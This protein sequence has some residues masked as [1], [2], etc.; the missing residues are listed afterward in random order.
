MQKN[1]TERKNELAK[2]K[3]HDIN[4]KGVRISL[5]SK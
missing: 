2:Q 5:L 3:A 1:D 4:I